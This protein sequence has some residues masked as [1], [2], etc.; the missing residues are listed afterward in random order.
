M[1]NWLRNKKPSHCDCVRCCVV[2]CRSILYLSYCDVNMILSKLIWSLDL[3][4]E[5]A[6]S[7]R[8]V[9]W[10]LL[11]AA[12]YKRHN[13]ILYYKSLGLAKHLRLLE[14]SAEI[15]VT[16]ST[17][18]LWPA[19]KQLMKTSVSQLCWF[20]STVT[21]ASLPFLR[22]CK[23]EVFPKPQMTATIPTFLLPLRAQMTAKIYQSFKHWVG[24]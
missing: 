17:F 20:V 14:T 2:L 19:K 11:A 12:A 4:K 3:L 5:L 6:V 9:C 15:N 18:H 24:A 1:W 16:A 21:F 22:I 10:T 7:S 8:F 23:Y 13:S